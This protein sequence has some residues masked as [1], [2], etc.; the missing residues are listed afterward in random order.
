MS[1][2]Y[3]ERRRDQDADAARKRDDKQHDAKLA[4]EERRKDRQEEREEKAQRRRDRAARRLARAARRQK[5]LTPANV[6]GKGTLGLVAFS[7][8]ASLPAQIIHFAS[9]YWMLFTVGIALE[10]GAWVLTAGVAYADEQ[11]LAPWVRWVLLALAMTAASYAAL[12]N[13]QYGQSLAEY[14]LTPG[15]TQ[16]AAMGLAG[17]TIG[18]PL[19]FEVRQWVR[20]LTTAVANPKRAEEKARAA[21]EKA[22][23]RQH[24]NVAKVADALL[25]DAAFGTLSREDAWTQ[26]RLIVYGTTAPGVTAKYVAMGTRSA[27]D[28]EAAQKL[29]PPTSDAIRQR[30]ERQLT[31]PVYILPNGHTTSP[32]TPASSQRATQ[33]PPSSKG[34]AKPPRKRPVPPVRKKG[35]SLPFHR[36]AKVAA[37]DTARQSVT[38]PVNGHHH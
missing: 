14:G 17:V 34:P 22:R 21:H 12:I 9:I 24:R 31:A 8:A 16:T 3:E 26:A 20:T 23:R 32:S 25:A 4:R 2:W 27:A 7:I 19:F 29:A 33:I 36:I 1:S 11:K 38:V 5:E 18:G 35:D 10:G 13:Y 15:Q 37:A 6:Y 30:I 28:L